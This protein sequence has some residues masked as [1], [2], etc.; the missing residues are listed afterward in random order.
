[1]IMF[2]SH[3]TISWLKA[4]PSKTIPNTFIIVRKLTQK[5]KKIEECV[6]TQWT[7][8]YFSQEQLIE[9]WFHTPKKIQQIPQFG[10]WLPI[11]LDQHWKM[12][13]IGDTVRI[14]REAIEFE[15]ETYGGEWGVEELDITGILSISKTKWVFLKTWPGRIFK[16]CK[17]TDNCRVPQTRTLITKK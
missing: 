15:E 11:R 5:W 1:M 14:Q 8:L 4:T 10:E 7:L 12:C 9:L 3:K 6:R 13:H 2:L 17:M 16:N